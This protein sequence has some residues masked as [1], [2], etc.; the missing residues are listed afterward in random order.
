V[1]LRVLIADDEP[2]GRERLRSFLRLEPDAEVVAECANGIEA[3]DAIRRHTP[4]LVFMDIQMPELDGFGVLEALD[5]ARPPAI[6]FVTAFDQFALQAFEVHAVDYLLKPFARDR[7]QTAFQRA[8]ER[9]T[10]ASPAPGDPSLASLLATLGADSQPLERLP[11]RSQGRISFVNTA[12][13]DWIGA[14]DNYVELHVGKM[15]HMVRM[16]LSTLAGR[17]S[18][19]RLVRISRSHMVNLDRIKE[20]R[21]KSHGDYLI[22]LQ[23]GTRLTGSRN[24]RGNLSSLLG[25]SR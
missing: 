8:R 25:K 2:L 10:G 5:G 16:S 13:I 4:Q 18:P 14:A 6:I 3:L 23:N 21:S 1:K 9:L 22:L 11:V 19:D 24:Y 15:T 12:E 7:F 17:L 20:I